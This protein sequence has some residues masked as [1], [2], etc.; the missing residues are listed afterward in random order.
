MNK[1]PINLKEEYPEIQPDAIFRFTCSGCGDC[2]RNVKDSVMVESLDLFRIARHLEMEV[3]EVADQY[4]DSVN[5]APNYP[6]LMLKTKAYMDTCVFLRSG[7]CS[8]YPARPRT[9]R[10]YPLSVSPD[11]K[12]NGAFLN[13]VVSKKKHHFTGPEYRSQDWI[14]AN[15]TA[16]DR[17]FINMDLRWMV[18]L[19]PLVRR[20]DDSWEKRLLFLSLLFRYF[21]F[22]TAEEFLPQ[23]KRNMQGF[24]KELQRLIST[25]NL[26]QGN[27]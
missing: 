1:Y 5:I 2:C 24:E 23:Y 10:M 26:I 21:Q 19:Y 3:S 15:F 8:I 6:V 9:C 20:V 22:D 18:R 12:R 25:K 4:T 13:H 16:D 11:D 17:A 14:D 27:D 7:R